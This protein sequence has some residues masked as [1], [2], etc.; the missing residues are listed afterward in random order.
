[1]FGLLLVVIL[2]SVAMWLWG[3]ISF[4]LLANFATR[5]KGFKAREAWKLIENLAIREHAYRAYYLFVCLPLSLIA[6]CTL[7]SASQQR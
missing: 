7:W 6:V 5:E 2:A 1:M 4:A 3:A